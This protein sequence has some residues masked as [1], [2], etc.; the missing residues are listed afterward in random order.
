MSESCE[1]SGWVWAFVNEGGLEFAI[2]GDFWQ[3]PFLKSIA[4][5]DLDG[6]RVAGVVGAVAGQPVFPVYAK[7][8]DGEI[9]LG[10]KVIGEAN[11]IVRIADM[12]RGRRNDLVVMDRFQPLEGNSAGIT[13]FRNLTGAPR[14]GDLDEDGDR[15]LGDYA[16][17]VRCMAG[18]AIDHPPVDRAP[19]EFVR[20]DLDHDSHV[21]PAVF[22]AFQA[23]IRSES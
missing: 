13:V 22:A 5:G 14:P 15:N 11:G 9:A 12:D 4:A 17:L 16:V 19:G 10:A 6:D 3:G 7:L 8:G 18:P 23:T 21:D 2:R 1:T 20:A